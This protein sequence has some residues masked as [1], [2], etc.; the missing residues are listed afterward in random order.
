MTLHLGC[1]NSS[2]TATQ[3][4][5]LQG[6]PPQTSNFLDTPPPQ[7]GDQKEGMLWYRIVP[8]QDTL[9][10]T[11]RLL[12][13]PSE[14][15][16]FL[17]GPWA[18]HDSWNAYI[19]IQQA[20]TP[21]G[22]CPVTLQRHLGRLDIQLPQAK[23]PWVELHYEVKLIPRKSLTDRFSPQKLQEQPG[24]FAYAPTLFILPSEKLASRLTQIPIELHTP[25]S[26]Q[27]ISTWPLVHSATSSQ[28]S[29]QHIHGYIAPDIRALRDAFLL[30]A[31]N[32]RL[33]NQSQTIDIAYD[34]RFKGDHKAFSSFIEDILHAYET[35]LGP[36]TT[37]TTAL[38]RTPNE[39]TSS[40]QRWGTG[41]R[42]G[43]VLELEPSALLD[44]S[45]M[46]LI[47][48]EAFHLWNGHALV[49]STS[50][51]PDTRWFKEGL[52]HYVAI[53][54]LFQMGRIS[55]REFLH[56]IAQAAQRYTQRHELY[57]HSKQKRAESAIYP[58]DKGVLMAL[59]LDQLLH[60]H[61]S[62]DLLSW[63]NT[64]VTYSRKAGSWR[65]TQDDLFDSLEPHFTTDTSQLHT[66]EGYCAQ[67]KR[68]DVSLFFAQ[69]GLHW[70]EA[71]NQR[72]AKLI[73]LENKDNQWQNIL[74][75]TP[76]RQE[77]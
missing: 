36:A 46:I 12:K 19:S 58:Y 65:Y 21:D 76:P 5:T 72:A 29:T 62:T 15:S 59:A 6:A 50:S 18:G 23:T 44:T 38:V 68:L 2:R 64:L 13:P 42:G 66:W 61:T 27:A 77:Q 11:L 25:S 67:D 51:E 9:A 35:N 37:H 14:L 48:H 39:Y 53:K 3:S 4:D 40:S 33:T 1:Q 7:P 22:P 8:Q 17:P 47:A 52:T 26:Q 70:L 41:R 69:L 34:P 31:E 43:F 55:E 57:P 20:R 49:P 74:K 63:L 30:V 75:Q 71:D 10:I 54:N 28:D 73:P 60:T 32:V 24:F 56:E 45:A 16:L